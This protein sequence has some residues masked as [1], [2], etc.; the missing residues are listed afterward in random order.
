MAAPPQPVLVDDDNVKVEVLDDAVDH[1]IPPA[2]HPTPAAHS[3]DDNPNN[4]LHPIQNAAS[5]ADVYF[6]GTENIVN[7]MLSSS[8]CYVILL[9]FLGTILLPNGLSK[10]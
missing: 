8:L 5:M 3:A 6:L 7:C 10:V 4:S 1:I 2:R 9:F